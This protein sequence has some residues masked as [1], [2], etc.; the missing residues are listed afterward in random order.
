MINFVPILGVISLIGSIIYYWSV[1]FSLI[2]NRIVKN[3]VYP[4]I[5]YEIME[6]LESNVFAFSVIY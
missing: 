2:N 3:S 6:I 1:K 4:D 5:G